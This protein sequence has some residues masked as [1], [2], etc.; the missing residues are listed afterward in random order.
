MK[1][2]EICQDKHKRRHRIRERSVKGNMYGLDYVDISQDQRTLTVYFLGKGPKTLKQ[3]NVRIE[4]GRRIRDIQVVGFKL[5]HESGPERDDYMQVTVDKP[6]DFST[7]TLRLVMPS[8][9]SQGHP[10]D[11]PFEGFDPRYSQVDFSFKMNCPRDLDC[12]PG[13]T[14]PPPTLVEPD[15]NY[16]AKDYASFRQLILDRLALI[17]PEWKERHIP[18]V[19]VTL[20]EVLGYVGDYLSYYQDAVATEAYLGTARQRISARRHVRLVDYPMHEGCNARAWV[21]V[22]TSRDISFDP[23]EFYFITGYNDALQVSSTML[24]EADVQIVHPGSYEVFQ[25]LVEKPSKATRPKAGKQTKDTTQPSEGIQLYKA[26][27]I[28]DFYTWGDTECCLPR[29][30]TSA[31]LKDRWVQPQAQTQDHGSQEHAPQEQQASEKEQPAP[32]TSATNQGSTSLQ[33]EH[34]LHLK[35]G[36]VLIFEEIIGPR[37]GNPADADPTHR[38][39]V[40]LTNVVPGVD[41]LYDRPVV[42]IEW[43]AEDALPFPLCLSALGPAPKCEILENISVARGN[44]I[45][46]DHG[47]TTRDEALGSVPTITTVSQC[48][49]EGHPKDSETVP[50]R[51]NPRLQEA[52]LTFSQPLPANAPAARLLTQDPRQAL[53]QIALTGTRDVFGSPVSTIWL[54]QRDLLESSGQDYHFVAEMDNDGFAHLRFGDGELGHQPEA[55]T[56]FTATY[57][58]GNGPSG[59]IG[60]GAISHIVFRNTT[61]ADVMLHPHN[62]FAATGGIAP[63]LLDEVR[64]FAPHYFRTN[65]Q[66]A[67]TADDYAQL[68]ER[69]PKVQRAAATL[70]WTGSWYEVLVAIDPLGTEEADQAL[71]HEIAQYLHRYRR[72]GYDLVVVPATY[73]SLDI[74]MTMCV[75]P[76]YLRGHVKAALLDLFSN[77]VL[78]GGKLGFFHPD[79]LTFGEGIPL[80]KLVALAQAVP[81]VESVTVNKL[82]RLFEGPNGELKNEFLPLG[83]LEIAR[84]DN[85]PNFPEHGKLVLTMRGG[86]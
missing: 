66:R 38:H 35:K 25:P 39:V 71:L 15:I 18:D 59:N 49:R 26:H 24:I 85:D 65:L 12:L 60:A 52:P 56:S 73:V 55:E 86:R 78:P 7:Y 42:E 79:N 44:I 47:Q 2:F 63:E 72:I 64:L 14:C 30:A 62:P 29:G 6:G 83:P 28:I 54:P 77:G 10:V 8:V 16:L 41:E 33:R 45:L 43:A 1:T 32:P 51:F 20:V 80:S 76:H 22:R 50:G 82:E 57:R 11:L 69:N 4:G 53:P 61:P 27:N 9:D 34:R 5:H 48:E 81:G 40:R 46:V 31:T 74:A 19:G 70:N 75:L 36:D 3:E 23:E 68:A 84:L 13:D 37:T 67:I 58:V 17:M 21:Y